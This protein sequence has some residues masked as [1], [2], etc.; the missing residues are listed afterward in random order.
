VS[1]EQIAF[2]M[3]LHP[4]RADEYRRR[5]D[6]I[7]P[8][9]VAVLREAGVTDY[10]IFLDRE[11]SHLFA[12]LRRPADHGMAALP[13]HPA[14][15]RWWAMMADIMETHPSN[16]PVAVPLAPMFHLD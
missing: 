13:E 7:A 10:S 3:M 2:R 9:L 16:E 5:H 11:T 15:R 8:E 1:L 14:M 12:V 6:A 4:G